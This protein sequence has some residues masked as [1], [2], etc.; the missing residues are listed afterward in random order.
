MHNCSQ[1]IH[2]S[3]SLMLECCS[4]STADNIFR[5][6]TT[7]HNR[8]KKQAGLEGLICFRRNDI[9]C[10][11]NKSLSFNEI[12]VQT[13]NRINEGRDVL[14]NERKGVASWAEC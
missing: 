3:H 13:R 7:E 2:V 1:E 14:G 4:M 9:H 10:L 12:I 8:D 5:P 11:G 6:C